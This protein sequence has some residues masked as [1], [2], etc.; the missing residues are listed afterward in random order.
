MIAPVAYHWA[1]CAPGPAKIDV[2]GVGTASDEQDNLLQ[3][4]PGIG[5]TVLRTFF[6]GSREA[7]LVAGPFGRYVASNPAASELLG[8]TAEELRLLGPADVVLG[9]PAATDPIGIWRNDLELRRKDGVPVPVE[10]RV[11][12]LQ[13]PLAVLSVMTAHDISDRRNV[14]RENAALLE[15]ERAALAA[16]E[17]ASRAGAEFLAAAAHELK[18]PVAVIKAYVELLASQETRERSTVEA[19]ALTALNSQ[20]D[21]LTDLVEN[22]LDVL[23][24]S[25][26][27]LYLERHHISLG[28]LAAEVVA[29]MQGLT[30]KHRLLLDVADP[31]EVDADPRRL[32]QVLVNLLGNAIKFSPQGGEIRVTVA[33]WDGAAVVSVEDAGVGIPATRQAQI[34]DQFYKAHPGAAVVYE[35]LGV[36]LFL[37]RALVQ[38]HGGTIWFTSV[39]GEG[40]TFSFSVPLAGAEAA[41]GGAG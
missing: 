12:A 6:T 40:S 21:R 22:L 10:A 27:R 18:T 36:G 1:H 25:L 15:R 39:E 24:L 23:R 8:Y 13:G 33:A 30:T 2:R 11:T 20:C 19:R 5:D 38:E 32:D 41:N 26:G 34:F 9:E 16:A 31:A 28:A 7:I 14:E 17:A 37:S 29:R 3:R 4:F 35:G